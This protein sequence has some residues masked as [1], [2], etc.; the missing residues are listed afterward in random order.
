MTSA[1][2]VL[3]LP[4]S[5]NGV[6]VLSLMSLGHCYL[7][8]WKRK[9]CDEIVFLMEIREHEVLQ[10]GPIVLSNYVKVQSKNGT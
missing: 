1:T 4:R 3:D 5:V 2:T 8:C 6:L 7:H 9:H 10:N